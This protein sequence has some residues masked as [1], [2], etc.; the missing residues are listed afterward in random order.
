MNQAIS[1]PAGQAFQTRFLSRFSAVSRSFALGD[2]PLVEDEP[3][4]PLAQRAVSDWQ[5]ERGLY[6]GEAIERVW[7]RFRAA[8]PEDSGRILSALIKADV[9]RRF[10]EGERPGIREYLERFPEL[11]GSTDRVVSLIYEEYCLR[12]ERGERL[13]PEDFCAL[14]RSWRDSL[15]SQLRYHRLL[16]EVVSPLVRPRF[17]EPGEVFG[18]F[19]IQSELGRGG[20]GR[21]Y[22]VRDRQLGGRLVAL[23]VSLDAGKEHQLQGKLDHPRIVPVLSVSF[24]D[25][26]GLRGLCMPY[27]PGK[28]LDQVILPRA[29]RTPSAMRSFSY[30]AEVA[31]KLGGSATSPGHPGWEGYP[32]RDSVRQAAWIVSQIA[33]GLAHAHSQ[34]VLHC[35]VKPGNVL[36]S[37]R[38]GPQLLDFNL[39]DEPHGADRAEAA[40]RGG[41]LPY[42]SPEQ[43]EAFLDPDRWSAVGP[44]ADL[45]ALGLV[46]REMVCG[47]RPAAPAP[48]VPLPRAIRELLDQRSVPFTPLGQSQPWI[49][50]AVDA[51]LS[52]C[53]AFRPEE[54]YG[55]AEELALDL[56]RFVA[57]EPLAY[58]RNTSQ[59]E[60][61]WDW[62]YRRWPILGVVLVILFSGGVFAWSRTLA[63]PPAI[64]AASWTDQGTGQ[65]KRGEA[66]AATKSDQNA[67]GLDPDSIPA[68]EGLGHA[69]K[70][71]GQFQQSYDHFSRMLA[72]LEQP[73][74]S[75]D[76]E[77][78]AAMARSMRAQV[79]VDLGNTKRQNEAELAEAE[80]LYESASADLD[81]FASRRFGS[82]NGFYLSSIR[83]RI[84][85]GHGE[86]ASK[87]EDYE[88]SVECFQHALDESAKAIATIGSQTDEKTREDARVLRAHRGIIESRLRIDRAKCDERG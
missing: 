54:R 5:L 15:V 31:K 75:S 46:L 10:E 44:A 42:M 66:F 16:S 40:H 73:G 4:C 68:H 9:A 48:G 18:Q 35:D 77:R 85:V 55:R 59:Q 84:W 39:A 78:D 64:L 12:E 63:P 58:A 43:L 62:L 30:Y 52:K 53:L 34:G 56:D 60:V 76:P 71:L 47:T 27:R 49:P 36:L 23:K 17:P 72:L 86:V 80:R 41:T 57:H 28:S 19:E 22:L 13:D 14:Y 69:Y 21:V 61:A 6:G 24:D 79:A 2:R 32:R 29:E 8:P 88:R 74:A 7:S 70:K 11:Y 51:I 65:L 83:F 67:L 81:I 33:K 38:D 37:L 1:S 26:S 82:E 87:R 20:A 25:E 3:V 45:Y 50:S